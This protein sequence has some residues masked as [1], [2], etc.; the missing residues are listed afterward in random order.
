MV[1]S[2]MAVDQVCRTAADAVVFDAIYHRLCYLWVIGQPQVVVAAE[3]DDI[4]TI[5]LHLDLLRAFAYA[6]AA[7]AV[8]LFFFAECPA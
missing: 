7:I 3:A 6:P 4:L 8:L 5:D 1:C 2:A